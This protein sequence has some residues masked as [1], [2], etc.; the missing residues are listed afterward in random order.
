MVL[1]RF[2]EKLERE[3]FRTSDVSVILLKALRLEIHGMMRLDFIYRFGDLHTGGD[4]KV[5]SRHCLSHLVVVIRLYN[6]TVYVSASKKL[7]M[8]DSIYTIKHQ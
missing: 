4:F 1:E 3:L 5:E 6:N 7:L 2:Y 8:F